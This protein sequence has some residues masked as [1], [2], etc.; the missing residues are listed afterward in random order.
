MRLRA[1][2]KTPGKISLRAQRATRILTVRGRRDAGKR[3]NAEPGLF[4]AKK[5][6]SESTAYATPF[7]LRE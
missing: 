3:T 1:E 2:R 5:D 6:A 7:L 4:A